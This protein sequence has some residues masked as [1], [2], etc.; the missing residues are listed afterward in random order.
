M[1]QSDRPTRRKILITGAALVSAAVAAIALY[2]AG[3]E[4]MIGRS[5]SRL[6][7]APPAANGVGAA[8][9]EA[10]KLS[11]FDQPHTLPDLRFADSDGRSLSLQD[12]RGRP[13]LLN[14]WATWCVPCR[15]EM[16]S[17]DRLQAKI[18][19]SELLV[20]PLSIDRQGLPVVKKFYDDLGLT[21]L[22]VY[23]D[24]SGKASSEVNTVGVP[25]TLLVDRDGRE[26]A[27]KVGPAEWDSPEILVLLR[28]HLGLRSSAQKASP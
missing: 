7:A 25:T 13:I 9:S 19:A 21:S 16:P 6:S 3:T 23:I 4:F 24:Q 11:F 8:D 27:R 5:S 17:L 26:I 18:G 2:Y 1:Q 20:L 28:E 10:F 22:G 15:E 14:I 12:F